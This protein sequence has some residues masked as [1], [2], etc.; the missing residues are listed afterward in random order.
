MTLKL[1]VSASALI[2]AAALANTAAARG[3]DVDD[4]NFAAAGVGNDGTADFLRKYLQE[5]AIFVQRV[6]TVL[7]R[8]D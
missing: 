2:F 7:P 4:N 8:E 3:I 5:Y 6:L 1:M